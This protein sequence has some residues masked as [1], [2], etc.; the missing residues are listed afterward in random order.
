MANP[1]HI[2]ILKQ[3]SAVWNKWFKQNLARGLPDLSEAD[4]SDTDLG[5]TDLRG[6]N[7]KKVI[8]IRANLSGANLSGANLSESFLFRAVLQKAEMR[9]TS[10]NGA[11]I[12]EADLQGANLSNAYLIGTILARSN[13]NSAQLNDSDCRGADF[14]GVDLGDANLGGVNFAGANL[15]GA[16]LSNADCTN[17]DFER[18]N[19]GKTILNNA[20]FNDAHFYSTIFGSNDLSQV[21]GLDKAVHHGP[22]IL[23][24][25]TIYR[26]KGKLQE[27]FLRGCELSD[28][29]IETAKL[30]APGLT[31]E[32]VTVIT[33]R[34]QELYLTGIP[35]DSC[36][37]SY[38]SRDEGFA[39]HLHDDLQKNGVRCWLAPEDTKAG[40]KFRTH[41]D[42]ALRDRCRL[43][44]LFSDSSIFSPGI[45][46]EVLNVLAMER[47]RDHKVLIPI[48]LDDSLMEADQPWAAEIR[49]THPVGDFSDKNDYQTAFEKLLKE[50][51]SIT[52]V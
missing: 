42:D 45:E 11:D 10:L 8:L 19:L 18:A 13:L 17:S 50:L 33:G 28:L 25:E 2:K 43:L 36:F 51:K 40:E 9:G 3:G 7:L 27:G 41:L 52:S 14:S 20:K 49:E 38:N 39:T 47:K 35:Y 48:L 23:N 37:I 4:L 1:E 22:S 21:T 15:T 34:I 16:D 12:S 6:V 31:S 44:I 5:D 46:K 29:Q 24:I 32:Q 26:S 30:A